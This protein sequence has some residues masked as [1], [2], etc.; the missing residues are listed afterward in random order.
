MGGPGMFGQAML[1][2]ILI[3]RRRLFVGAMRGARGRV[4][5]RPRCDGCINLY[6]PPSTLSFYPL[7]SRERRFR[8]RG[9]IFEC[10]VSRGWELQNK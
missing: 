7:P 4:I 5:L 8:L 9:H 2:A 3:R 10:K 6:K 1:I